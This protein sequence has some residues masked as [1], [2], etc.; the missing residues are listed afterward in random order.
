VLPRASCYRHALYAARFDRAAQPRAA[1]IVEVLAGWASA[2]HPARVC[3]ASAPPGSA[4]ADSR[5]FPGRLRSCAQPLAQ[6]AVETE[7]H[8]GTPA[9]DVYQLIADVAALRPLV[10]EAMRAREDGY[11]EAV[12]SLGRTILAAH[13][14]AVAQG[15]G[16]ALVLCDMMLELTAH[17]HRA[18]SEA[19]L[20]FW[21][22]LQTL[23]MDQR[24][25]ALRQAVFSRLLEVRALPVLPSSL[26]RNGCMSERP[27]TLKQPACCCLARAA[28][29]ARASPVRSN[30]L[31]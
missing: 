20:E 14:P 26:D 27:P 19:A 21:D 5:A 13:P 4:D 6:A 2:L 16:Q 3:R 23:E 29:C 25:P 10:R 8:P 7:T 17:P 11:C 12:A 18:S 22:E 31:P 28:G 15:E 9:E 1:L 24:H 30:A